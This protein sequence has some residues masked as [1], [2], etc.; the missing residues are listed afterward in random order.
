MLPV[1]KLASEAASCTY[2]DP[3]WRVNVGFHRRIEILRGDIQDRRFR[4]LTPRIADDDVEVDRHIGAFACV[5]DR[6]STSDP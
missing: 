1:A 4:L 5:C 3:E 6:R 2:I